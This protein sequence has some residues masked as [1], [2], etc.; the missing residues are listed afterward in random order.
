MLEDAVINNDLVWILLRVVVTFLITILA[1]KIFRVTWRRVFSENRIHQKFIKNVLTVFI[2]VSGVIFALNHIPQFNDIVTALLAGSGIAALTIGLA[3]QES[4]SNAFNGLFISLFKPFDV[5]DRIHLVNANITGFI[6]DIT[7][8][9]TVVRTFM[10]SRII[11][12]NSVMNKELIENS[13]FCNA[14]AS[15]F[16]DVVITYESNI[17]RACE[18]LAETIG[19]HEKFVDTRSEEQKET[20]PKVPVLVRALGLHGAEIRASMWTPTVAENFVACSEIRKRLIREF[21]KEGIMIAECKL[22]H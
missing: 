15:A 11:I 9:H 7:L 5:G 18:I 3:A 19:N 14:Q 10:N 2:W 12:P 1:T 20:E 8:R 17:E 22:C 4:L 13:S 21:E 16:V 6:E